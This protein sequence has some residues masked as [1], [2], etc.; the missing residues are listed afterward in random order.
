MHSP[1]EGFGAVGVVGGV[2][3][4]SESHISKAPGI[5]GQAFPL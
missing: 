3:S 4:A 1:A 2:L 5:E